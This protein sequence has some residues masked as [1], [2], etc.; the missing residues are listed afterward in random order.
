GYLLEELGALAL[1]DL[2]DDVLAA[3]PVL[4]RAYPV[5]R[6]QP[7]RRPIRRLLRYIRMALPPD[8]R[9]ELTGRQG[10]PRVVRPRMRYH[11]HT[12]TLQ[13]IRRALR[14]QHL[15]FDYAPSYRPGIEQ[16]VV[17]PLELLV[18]GSHTYLLAYCPEPPRPM[19]ER[20]EGYVEFRVDQIVTGSARMLPTP[21]PSDLPPRPV[22]RIVCELAPVVARRRHVLRWFSNT[23]ITYREDGSA[24][25]TAT[26]DSLWQAR[27]VLLRHLEHVRVLEPP[28]LI[29][30]IRDTIR[31]LT[32]LYD[33]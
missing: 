25:V 13:T 8:R 2:P 27:H 10:A 16:H 21:L 19:E 24:L 26:V 20:Y 7:T 1:L 28:E 22:W 4:R 15:R 14:Q 29:A 5:T 31:R 12:P 17:A 30:L 6:M 18:R 32:A 9:G 11:L 23:E 3:I 33:R